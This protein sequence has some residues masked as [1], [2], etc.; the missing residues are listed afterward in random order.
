MSQ[1]LHIVIDCSGSMVE[2]DK[3]QVVFYYLPL[4]S[5]FLKKEQDDLELKLYG[6]GEEV[7]STKPSRLT[8]SGKANGDIFCDF[9]NEHKEE[10][11]MLISDGY[12]SDELE[13][14]FAK[15]KKVF[16]LLLGRDDVS[17]FRK[18]QF[19]S[20][21]LLTGE[22]L[23]SDLHFLSAMIDNEREA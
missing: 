21:R 16:L 18:K 2:Q 6:W 15:R 8:F 20:G 9:L 14:V 10:F 4:I 19:A 11:V 12:Y 7:A 3:N 22:N 17:Y 1:V 23:L 13:K 5:R